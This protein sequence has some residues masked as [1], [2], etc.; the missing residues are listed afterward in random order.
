MLR[1]QLGDEVFWPAVTAYI[2]RY[3]GSVVETDDFRR[4]LEERSGKSLARF[5]D[6]YLL[7]PG[8]PELEISFS[9]D[10]VKRRGT[11]ELSQKQ[12]EK[13]TTFAFPLEVAF[14][15]AGVEHV[16]TIEVTAASATLAVPMDEDPERIAIDPDAKALA[17]VTFDPGEPR[18]RRSLREGRTISER[19]FAGRRLVKS[20]RRVDTRAVVDA[21]RTEP[22]HGVRVKWLE[23]LGEAQTEASLEALLAL[24][25]T[26]APRDAREGVP[27]FRA[28]GRYRDPAVVHAVATRL[29][30]LAPLEGTARL[31]PRAREAAYEALGAQRTRAPLARLEDAARNA[32]VDFI[33]MGALRALGS[34]HEAQARATLEALG[35]PGGASLRARPVA[36]SALGELATAVEQNDRKE[37][38][39]WLVDRLRDPDG[40]VRAAAASALITA[41][42]TESRDVLLAYAATLTS[43]ERIRVE[44][45]VAS[46]S[47]PAE[48]ELSALRKKLE[49]L[50][51]DSRKLG[52]RVEALERDRG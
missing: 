2:E 27:L 8:F 36:S 1:S 15:I 47:K 9:Y 37:I 41:R 4:I 29:D 51:A 21:Y 6:D 50:E 46:L 43:Q 42:A 28:L 30:A 38:V 12:A 7:A 11:F 32:P 33:R 35:I 39:E 24:A 19:I 17:R 3:A 49:A 16:R 20:G 31:G 26:H 14:V 48:G 18:T 45:S 5:F 44:R 10:A 34:S 25:E 22:E 40:K 23:A 52:G 13:G